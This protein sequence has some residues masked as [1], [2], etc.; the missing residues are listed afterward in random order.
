MC[1]WVWVWVVFSAR[2]LLG[3]FPVHTNW[4]A[5]HLVGLNL[6]D[7]VQYIGELYARWQNVRY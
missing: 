5:D 7:G 4:T 6:L 1:V 2:A 3:A